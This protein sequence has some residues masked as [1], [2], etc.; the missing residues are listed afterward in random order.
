VAGKTTTTKSTPANPLLPLPCIAAGCPDPS[1]WDYTV[2]PPPFPGFT[3]PFP[4]SRPLVTGEVIR[5]CDPHDNLICSATANAVPST[6][7]PSAPG[8][9]TP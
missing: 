6:S 8:N 9:L 3:W 1:A 4:M 7:D 5:L 2:A